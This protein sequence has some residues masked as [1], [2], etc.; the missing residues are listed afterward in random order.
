ML[1]TTVRKGIVMILQSKEIHLMGTVIQLSVQHENPE[2][3]LNDVTTRLRGYEKRFSAHDPNSELMEI[4]NQAGKQPVNVHPD[5]YQLIKI[6]KRHSLPDNSSLNIAIGPLVQAWHIGF[7]D[8][9]R[10]FPST[11]QSLLNQTKAED[12]I[13]DDQAQTVYLQEPGMFLDLGALAKGFIADLII[14]DFQL[15]NVTAGLI[16]LGGNVLTYGNAPKHEDGYWRVGIQNPFLPRGEHVAALK[17]FNQSVV[18]SGIYERT[19]TSDDGI[20]HH[21]LDPRTGYP[22][23]TKIAGLTVVSNESVDGEIWTSRLFGKTPRETIHTLDQLNGM[24]GIVITQEGE[25]YYSKSLEPY[26]VQ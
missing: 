4:N 26:L 15:M 11:I 6:G 21:I 24:G 8:A 12:I 9:H 10:P 18:T 1:V 7:A 23:E 17:I 20:Y 13:L 3:I 2:V 19:F 25:M 16:N 5:L 14:R 22:V